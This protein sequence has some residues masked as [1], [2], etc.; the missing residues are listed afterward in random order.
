MRFDVSQRAQADPLPSLGRSPNKD[1]PSFS[2]LCCREGVRGRGTVCLTCARSN[3][4]LA[5]GAEAAS[6]PPSETLH[7]WHHA[8]RH[9]RVGQFCS[10]GRKLFAA[11]HS[12]ERSAA[13]ASWSGLR[14]ITL[15][16]ELWSLYLWL[17]SAAT[18]LPPA[19]SA[20]RWLGGKLLCGLWR[21]IVYLCGTTP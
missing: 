6:L 11:F 19:G 5:A 12:Q 14:S 10:Q 1:T 9:R 17:T 13:W 16:Q 8:R 7:L 20:P 4:L 21:R 2:P 18:H 3:P 15:L